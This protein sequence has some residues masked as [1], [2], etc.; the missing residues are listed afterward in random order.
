ML[1][2][3]ISGLDFVFKNNYNQPV[4]IQNYYNGVIT[5]QVYGNNKDKQNIE[6]STSIDKVTKAPIKKKRTQR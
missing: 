3:L 2:Y 4:Y 6:I 1:W 5:C